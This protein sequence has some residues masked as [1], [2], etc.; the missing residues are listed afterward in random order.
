MKMKSKAKLVH[1]K[2]K[3][4]NTAQNMPG[5]LFP[6]FFFMCIYILRNYANSF[7]CD[8]HLL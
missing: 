8:D 7:V 3:K 6:H 2:K 4:D 1:L 5:S